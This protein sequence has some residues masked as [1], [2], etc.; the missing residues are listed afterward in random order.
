MITNTNTL[1]RVSMAIEVA[2]LF[3]K[4]NFSTY[5][6]VELAMDQFGLTYEEQSDEAFDLICRMLNN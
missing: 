6:A 1:N 4:S 2:T 3:I 5:D